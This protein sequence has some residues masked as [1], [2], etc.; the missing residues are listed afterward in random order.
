MKKL[1]NRRRFL[2]G[3]LVASAAATFPLAKNTA[4]ATFEGYPD[5]MGVLVDLSRCVGCRSCEAAC[6]KEQ[7]LP[8][9]EKPFN[10]FSVFDE[11]SHGQKRRTDETRYTVVNRHDIPGLN[12]PLFRKIQCNH[13]LEPA[14]LTS[15]FVNA[16]TK[17]PE[18]AVIYDASVC[19]GCRTCMIACPFNIP[20][21]RYSSAFDPKIMKC[22]FCHDTRLVKG[23]PPACV[24]ACP[25]EVMTFGRR[26]DILEM[27]RQR[28]RENPA[29]YVDHIYGE[30]EAGGTAWMYLSPVPFEQVEFNTAVPKE[31]ILN[32]VKDFLSIVPMVLTI[33]PALFT[34]IHLLATKK[35]KMEQQKKSE[36]SES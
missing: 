34:G 21:F 28:I 32:Y 8:A 22:I 1:I 15:C 36:G 27:G 20:A 14:C 29:A 33:W 17:T 4:A 6:N 25:Q 9:P 7:N 30:H 2:Q 31:P 12:H 18:G 23:L 13:C 35:E 24:E 19:V 26:T 16:Y 5:S 11:L 10:D 3:S